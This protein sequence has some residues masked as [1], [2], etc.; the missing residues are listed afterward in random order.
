MLMD[1]ELIKEVKKKKEFSKLPDSIVKKALELSDENVKEARAFLRKY[2]GVFLTNKVMKGK[3]E[4]VLSS[5]ISSKLRDYSQFYKRIFSG[6]KFSSVI[7]LGCGA[8]GFSYNS[9][10][11]VLGNI[12]YLGIE[13]SGQV[14]ENTNE[15]FKKQN[16]VDAKVLCLDL[17][18]KEKIFDLVRKSK[19]PKVILMLQVVDALESLEKNFSK[20]L[21]LGLEEILTNADLL[22]ITMPLNSI[23]GKKK[24]EARRSWISTFLEENFVVKEDFSLG[25]ERIFLVRKK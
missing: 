18:D 7:D 1:K 19:E 21:L 6:K 16:F 4:E 2:F 20:E 25:N 5:H 3:T 24:F 8:N 11:D 12:E 10:K 13:A 22:I 9:L 23:S 17:F 15:Y 14:V